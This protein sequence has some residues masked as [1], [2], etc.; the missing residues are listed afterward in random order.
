MIKFRAALL[1]ASA[2]A[3]VLFTPAALSGSGVG[4]VFNL[5]QTNTVDAQSVLTGN[6]PGS[7]MLR[8]QNTGGD[9]ALSLTVEPGAAPLR[10][11]ST[12]KAPNLNADFVDGFDAAD[13]WK[14]GGNAGSPPGSFIGTTDAQ[15]LSF[16]TNNKQALYIDPSQNVYTYARTTG[17]GGFTALLGTF[18][19]C[20][21]V[22]AI[23][24]CANG[25]GIKGVLGQSSGSGIQIGVQGSSNTV[26]CPVAG[27]TGVA[28]C[29]G[30]GNNVGILE[31]S[32]S[33]VG[34]RGISDG[35]VGVS[36]GSNAGRAVEGIARTGIGVYGTGGSI[37]VIG[38]S[39]ARG[40]IGT[41]GK[42]SCA[43]S[44]AVGGCVPSS[45]SADGVYGRTGT[46]AAVR[47]ATEGG[48]SLFVGEYPVGTH[49]AR[50]DASGKGYFNG[51]T[52][53]G[54]ADYAESIRA[55]DRASL[56]PGDV[57][58]ID[59]AHGYAVAV[60]RRPYSRLVAGVYS[61]KPAVLAVGRHSVDDSLTGEV[62]VAMVGVVPTKV[63]AENGP[64]RAGNL[65][66]TAR[67]PGYAMRAKPLVVRG[68]AI[69][70][71]GAILGKALE[72]LRAGKGTIR[73]LVMLR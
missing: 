19:P 43:G 60:S 14:L 58:A 61:T 63:S 44:Y 29:S 69:Y 9:V 33:Q 62:P 67:T 7:S 2:A 23:L 3:L 42:T 71:T 68:V 64:V 40:V 48:G 32:S 41:L 28:G 55:S 30:I 5:G 27:S 47:A 45:S 35:G 25:T 46:G 72:P 54:G 10:T 50:I 57:L 6:A 51:G 49:Q 8:V 17:Y 66:V 26:T 22:V 4:D 53:T 18:S 36:G 59:P 39:S 16:R 11:N 73:V 20:A 24:A 37:G 34:V 15:G 52:Q 13:F 1:G 56:R 70:P 65:L 38:D 12:V 21:P 31:P